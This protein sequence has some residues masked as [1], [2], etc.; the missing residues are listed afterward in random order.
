MQGRLLRVFGHRQLLDSRLDTLVDPAFLLIEHRVGQQAHVIRG[1]AQG[2]LEDRNGVLA[3]HTPCGEQRG[4]ALFRTRRMAQYVLQ[5]AIAEH[6]VTAFLL[7]AEGQI[8][9]TH[10]V[11]GFF[12]LLARHVQR[13]K[14]R[15]GYPDG[16]EQRYEERQAEDKQRAP[17]QRKFVA[18]G[19]Q[20]PDP[21][22]QE[23]TA[24]PVSG[25]VQQGRLADWHQFEEGNPTA[26]FKHECAA[27]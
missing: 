24:Q 16:A 13:R 6:Q 26:H 9:H 22:A 11:P 10:R 3:R 21:R 19:Q 14:N 2:Q 15:N 27:K 25:G 4:E 8:R 17:W 12:L 23:G 5:T 20:Q 18:P 7:R 1:V